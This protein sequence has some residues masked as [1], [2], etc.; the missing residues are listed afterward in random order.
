MA[1]SDSY[2]EFA[3]NQ[4]GCGKSYFRYALENMLEIAYCKNPNPLNKI[5]I[6]IDDFDTEAIKKL[7]LGKEIG[8]RSI[9]PADGESIHSK[10]YILSYEKGGQRHYVSIMTSSNLYMMAFYY[11]TNSVLVIHETD[12]TGDVYYRSFGEKYSYGMLTEN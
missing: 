8:F 10:D 3:S 1:F 5:S 12:E 9:G 2:I 4:F 7:E 6:K 11:R